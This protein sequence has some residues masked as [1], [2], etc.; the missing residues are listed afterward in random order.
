M[1]GTS[2]VG[3]APLIVVANAEHR[4][5][6]AE[7]LRDLGLTGATILLEPVAR[8]TAPAIVAAALVALSR[9]P[10]AVLLVMP[11]D[12]HLPDTVAFQAAVAGGL[13]AARLGAFVIFGTEALR[14]AEGYGYLRLTSER[15]GQARKVGDFVEKPDLATARRL[16]AAQA[17]YWN[18]GIFLLPA[19]RLLDELRAHEP[20]V[21]AAVEAAVL[22]ARQDLD[23][24]RLDG[25]SFAQSPSI[26]IDHALMERTGNL[27]G[28]VANYEWADLGT[29]SSLWE[30]EPKDA[31]GNVLHGEVVSEGAHN[32]YLRS[33]GPLLAA[34]GVK[35]LIVVVTPDAVLVAPRS[36]DQQ[37][38]E[39]VERLKAEGHSAATLSRR[40]HRPWGWYE[41]IDEGTAFQVKHLMVRP[42]GRLS[43][44]QHTKRAE[45]WVVI[46]G[47]AHVE[48]D[49]IEKPLAANESIYIPVGAAHRLSN[50]GLTPLHVVEVQTGTYF[51]EDDI[52]RLDDEYGREIPEF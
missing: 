14:A 37:V 46:A 3:S 33:D 23:F 21:V 19:R 25:A 28:V 18:C 50:R 6:V 36:A 29:W 26:S 15:V 20:A 10:G 7:Q 39:L 12:H 13:T 51:G 44:Q 17:Y 48:L 11:A 32:S 40:N 1:R 8:N 49:G 5:V 45:H 27:A 41:T 31:S 43:L 42:M 35:D 16:F 22:G 38:K 2:V 34:I 9:D 4:F 30:A 52:V 47:T 24:L